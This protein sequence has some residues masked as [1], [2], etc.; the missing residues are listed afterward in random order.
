LSYVQLYN[1]ISVFLFDYVQADFSLMRCFYLG[2]RH[3]LLSSKIRKIGFDVTSDLSVIADHFGLR[4][5]IIPNVCCLADRAQKI[6]SLGFKPSYSDCLNYF[7]AI[8]I[9]KTMQKSNW[10]VRNIDKTNYLV[11]DVVCLFNLYRVILYNYKINT[12][13]YLRIY[14]IVPDGFRLKLC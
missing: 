11:N 5:K 14:G 13:D 1:G 3:A 4:C 6:L 12:F 7:C 9:D 2:L 10:L 8:G